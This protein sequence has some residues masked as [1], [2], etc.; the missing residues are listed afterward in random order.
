MKRPLRS[1]L[2]GLLVVVC[3][4]PQDFAPPPAV[5][6]GQR[7]SLLAALPIQLMLLGGQEATAQTMSTEGTRIDAGTATSIIFTV[8]AALLASATAFLGQAVNALKNST[9][10]QVTALKDSTETQV[11]ALKDSTAAQVTAIEKRVEIAETKFDQKFDTLI[12]ALS[13][14]QGFEQQA[15]F[16]TRRALAKQSFKSTRP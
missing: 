4:M 9:E 1:L 12:A 15:L 16:T 8:V 2:L 7:Q 5:G 13:K 11:T 14:K 10:T 6:V 3:S